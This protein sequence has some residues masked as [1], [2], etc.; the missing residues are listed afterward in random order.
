MVSLSILRDHGVTQEVLQKALAGDP[1]GMDPALGMVNSS[2]PAEL[3]DQKEKAASLLRRI[4]SRVQEGMNRNFADFK[5][6][7]ALDLAWDTPFRQVS[8]TLLQ[9]LMDAN[10][11]EEKIYKAFQDWGLTHL[12]SERLDPKD[13]TKKIRELNVPLFFN[14]FVPLVQAYVKI[15][16]S[17]IMNDRRLTPF[18]EYVPAKLTTDSMVKCAAITDRVQVVSNQYGYYDV[19]K[20]AVLKMLHYGFCFQFVKE[21]WHSEEQLRYATVE[22][23]QLDQMTKPQ[24]AE[25]PEGSDTETPVEDDS[26]APTAETD[27]QDAP[28]IAQAP[29]KGGVKEGDE[30]VVTVREGLRY[31]MPHPTRS[32][33][34][35][36][37]GPFTLNYDSGCEFCGYWRIER[38]RTLQASTFWNKDR[39]ALGTVDLVSSNP[40]FFQSVYSACTMAIPIQVQPQPVAD[41]AAMAFGVGAGGGTLDREKQLAQLYYGT[42]HGDQGVIVT[43]YF[44]KLKPKDWGLGDYEYPVW[45]RFCVAGDGCTVLYA[46]PLPYTP[47]IYYGYDADESRTKNA[48]MSLEILPF[49]DQFSNVLTQIILTA[50][51][52]L[53]NMVFIDEAQVE[54]GIIEKIKNTGEKMF[55]TLN[56][57]KFDSKK[58]A[59]Y[60]NK[61]AEAAQ[62]FKFPQGNTAELT[63][64]LK[65]ILDVL[66]RVLVMSSNEVGQAASHEQTKEEIRNIAENTSSRLVFT[67][68][69]VDIAAEAQKRQIYAGLMNYGDKDMYVHIPSDSML[70]PD[71]LK[72][73]NFTYVD[74]G[75][76]PSNGSLKLYSRYHVKMNAVAMDLWQFASTR[77]QQDRVQNEKIAQALAQLFQEIMSNPI[78]APAVGAQQAIDWANQ[79]CYFS[80]M[81]RD[82]KLRSIAPDQTPEQ[83]QQAAQQQLQQVAQ[84]VLGQVNDGLKQELDPLLKSVSQNAG[85]IALLF[86]ALKIDAP[87]P[88]NE[89][90]D[91]NQPAPTTEPAGQ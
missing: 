41:G 32:F 64:V 56:I 49:Q 38:W 50:K 1:M 37:H 47:V 18:F 65:T 53:A 71:V 61:I 12:I 54:N 57:F 4:R 91:P 27:E 10:P 75:L 88:A 79:I 3:K 80:G 68:T 72:A 23:V 39:I 24:A 5:L 77:D 48:S 11:N 62:S 51:Q 85:D 2:D 83:Q 84:Q 30:I 74:N 89:S 40:L 44:E 90:T 31:H 46:E 60:Q 69:P 76:K 58:A 9:Q 87:N 81:P 8:P 20:Q 34:D 82:F 15:R 16:W 13:S 45:F 42:E 29:K 17:K 59:K 28:P 73:M 36:A 78:T 33:Y 25:A 86:K 55:R 52:N 7:H 66:E 67:T 70:T 6:Y 26:E 43:E 22:D 21:A 63:T 35:L 14:V 19:Q